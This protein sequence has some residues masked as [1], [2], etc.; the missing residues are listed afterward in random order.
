MGDMGIQILM[1]KLIVP[2]QHPRLWLPAAGAL[3]P[4]TRVHHTSVLDSPVPPV[5]V[6]E[7]SKIFSAVNLR[8]TAED[9]S[10]SKPD[11]RS[12]EVQAAARPS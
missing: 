1:G 4:T 7:P 2:G 11:L 5:P 8:S 12:S 9:E 10:A 6:H 3:S